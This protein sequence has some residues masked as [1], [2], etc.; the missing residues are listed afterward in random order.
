MKLRLIENS[1]I[2]SINRRWSTLRQK[3]TVFSYFLVWI[4]LTRESRLFCNIFSIV[5]L[6]V[7]FFLRL[8]IREGDIFLLNFYKSSYLK[9]ESGTKFL[10][11]TISLC[12]ATFIYLSLQGQSKIRTWDPRTRDSAIFDPGTRDTGLCDLGPWYPES[13]DLGPATL[14]PGP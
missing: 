11:K 4:S 12:L 3:L 8:L 9:D 6:E 14:R 13:W 5:M 1:G 10:C 7:V 2:I